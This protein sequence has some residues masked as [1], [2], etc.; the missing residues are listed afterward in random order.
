MLNCKC[1]QITYDK[2]CWFI[3]YLYLVIDLKKK[4]NKIDNI[5]WKETKID[6]NIW[7]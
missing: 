3:I 7:K 1:K 5:I 6:N 2:K 4:K